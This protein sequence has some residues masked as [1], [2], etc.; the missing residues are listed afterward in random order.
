MPILKNTLTIEGE[1][2]MVL[3]KKQI[4]DLNN[5][6]IAAQQVQL[7]TLLDNLL[8]SGGYESSLDW[9][10]LDELDDNARRVVKAALK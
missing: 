8:Q 5:M 1:Y 9:I 10:N 6:N 2:S 4:K 7:G 3:T